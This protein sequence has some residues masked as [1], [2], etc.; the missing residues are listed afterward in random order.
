MHI[1]IFTGMVVRWEE[2]NI[3]RAVFLLLLFASFTNTSREESCLRNLV[4]SINF[5]N[6][7]LPI[8]SYC[9][10]PETFLCMHSFNL[11]FH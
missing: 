2:H 7:E 8:Y 9:I 10:Y 4:F 5:T 11:H 6:I 1:G 3:I